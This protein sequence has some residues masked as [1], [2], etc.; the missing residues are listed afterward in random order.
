MRTT[1]PQPDS[2]NTMRRVWVSVEP[3]GFWAVQ[4]NMEPLSSA[5]TLSRTSSRPSCSSLPSSRRPPT[6]VQVN[7]GSGKTSLCGHTHTHRC[8]SRQ[9]HGHRLDWSPPSWPEPTQEQQSCLS[10]FISEAFP[11]KSGWW[12]RLSVTPNKG[13]NNVFNQGLF[14][15]IIHISKEMDLAVQKITLLMVPPVDLNPPGSTPD[16]LQRARWW[17]TV[18]CDVVIFS[19]FFISFLIRFFTHYIFCVIYEVV[20]KIITRLDE[21]H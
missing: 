10:E 1:L 5:G 13:Y 16:T 19:S 4:R 8:V 2:P 15:N 9:L 20:M 3:R 21:I 11:V 12:G 17:I 14:L 6:L 18:S 7:M